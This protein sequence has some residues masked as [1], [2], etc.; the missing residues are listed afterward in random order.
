[1]INKMVPS[2]KERL[3]DLDDIIVTKT[4]TTGKI[5]YGNRTFYDFAG[6]S[7]SE[8]IGKQHNIIRHPEMPRCI[9][10]ILWKT[11]KGGEEI[12]AFVN[13]LSANGDNYWVLAHVTPS[14]DSDGLTVGYHSSRRS[15]NRPI[16][17][18]HIIPLY[19]E[20]LAV[21]KS[22]SSPRESMAAS[23]KKID[24]IL[25]QNKMGINEFVFSL[26]L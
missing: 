5:T 25:Q 22:I 4:D 16:L 21:E 7:E 23:G 12:F 9:F 24:N 19:R 1:M 14:L 6:L 17:E 26:G 15:P 20:L 8:C 2:G 11:L 18:K 10:E 13:N 3:L